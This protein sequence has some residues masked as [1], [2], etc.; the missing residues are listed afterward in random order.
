MLSALTDI[1][2][3]NTFVPRDMVR[4]TG[5]VFWFIAF[6]VTS[7]QCPH[8]Q[9]TNCL[10]SLLRRPTTSQALTISD[11]PCYLRGVPADA[12]TQSALLERLSC[13]VS[14]STAFTHPLL[15]VSSLAPSCC[16]LGARFLRNAGVSV[17][18]R[19][20]SSTS[21]WARHDTTR[22]RRG[23]RSFHIERPVFRPV[24][25]GTFVRFDLPP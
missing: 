25:R 21:E 10:F 12:I 18:V 20:P 17:Y 22:A 5:A 9:G 11:E 15:F 16:S 6:R 4:L 14:R 24:G 8:S 13:V 1:L 2:A 7:P 19:L 3:K 23:I